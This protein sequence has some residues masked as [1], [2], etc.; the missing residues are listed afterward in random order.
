[1]STSS[2]TPGGAGTSS[3]SGPPLP[4]ILLGIVGGLAVLG[5]AGIA[6][7]KAGPLLGSKTGKNPLRRPDAAAPGVE[8]TPGGGGPSVEMTAQTK[9][10]FAISGKSETRTGP[11]GGR[12]G[13]SPIGPGPAGSGTSGAALTGEPIPGVDEP[14]DSLADESGP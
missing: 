10:A 14:P 5:G 12:S 1:M 6:V 9:G 2:P 4:L 7:A 13:G 8:P 11:R 3:E